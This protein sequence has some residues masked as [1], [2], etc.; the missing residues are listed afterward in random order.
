M[1]QELTPVPID[2]LQKN[3]ELFQHVEIHVRVTDKFIKLNVAGDSFIQILRKLTTKGVVHVYLHEEDFNNIIINLQSNLKSNGFFDPATA[4][5]KKVAVAEEVMEMSR[6]FIKKYGVNKEVIEA[7]RETN[8][9]IQQLLK[10]TPGL[11]AFVK[12][13]KDHCSEEFMKV[14]VTNFLV[15]LV[16]EQFPWK[17][18]LIVQKTILAG[19]L[20][21]ITLEGPEDFAAIKNYESRGGELPD[22]LRLHPQR[23]A[24]ILHRKRDLI[25]MET[26]NIVELHHERPDGTGFPHGFSLSRFNQLS[27]IFIIS[28]R[29]V[30]KLFDT[31]FNYQKQSESIRQLQEIYQGPV[32][33]KAVDALRNVIDN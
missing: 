30:E 24:E 21:D 32:F 27:A 14:N 28:Q 17:S 11:H 13:F 20:C 8:G 1:T 31:E 10:E 23:A 18:K 33:D 15:A 12:R 3:P 2:L 9:Q 4:P 19:I 7:L 16:I 25:P 6:Q 22:N 29:F 5:E 26:I